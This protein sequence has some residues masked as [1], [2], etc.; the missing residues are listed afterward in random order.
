M[1]G[2]KIDALA[3]VFAKTAAGRDSLRQRSTLLTS[4]QQSVLILMDGVRSL[5]MLTVLIPPQELLDTVPYLEQLGL[6]ARVGITT[7]VTPAVVPAIVPVVEA[8]PVLAQLAQ[9]GAAAGQAQSQ[10]LQ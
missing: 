5:R 2:G 8:L 9:D 1:S 7:Q 4:R 3:A 6:I 10:P